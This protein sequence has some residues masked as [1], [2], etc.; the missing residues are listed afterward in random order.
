MWGRWSPPHPLTVVLKTINKL[1]PPL[2]SA[3]TPLN[4]TGEAEQKAKQ[5]GIG[6]FCPSDRG[7]GLPSGSSC[8]HGYAGAS[9]V[10]QEELSRLFPLTRVLSEYPELL[11]KDPNPNA[12][13]LEGVAPLQGTGGMLASENMRAPEIR[14]PQRG[15]LVHVFYL[16]QFHF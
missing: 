4:H 7:L 11:Q 12:R 2:P 3:L 14:G 5:G 15:M 13:T 8:E 1:K 9:K 16:L 10:C 6:W